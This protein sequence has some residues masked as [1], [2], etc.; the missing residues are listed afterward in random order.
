MIFRT[1]FRPS[2]VKM[3]LVFSLLLLPDCAV[4]SLQFRSLWLTFV[5][6][7]TLPLQ[8]SI[9]FWIVTS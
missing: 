7:D 6:S 3:F 2:A 5:V 9:P 4:H 1:M 8:L